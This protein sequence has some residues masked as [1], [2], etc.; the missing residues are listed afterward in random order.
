[1]LV[2]QTSWSFRSVTTHRTI[3][4]VRVAACNLVRHKIL[5]MLMVLSHTVARHH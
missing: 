5:V 4:I 2:P 1:V 3:C